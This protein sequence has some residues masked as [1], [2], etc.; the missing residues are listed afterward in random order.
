MIFLDQSQCQV[1]SRCDPGRRIH[2]PIADKYWVRVDVGARAPLD[3]KL[4]P[5]PMSCRMAA[6]QQA[7]S[8]QEHRAGADRADSPNSSSDLPEPSHYFSVYLIVLNGGSPGYEQGVDRPANLPKRLMRR[9]SQTA[10][11]K[12]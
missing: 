2:I 12:K 8:S 11:R 7:D 10:V 5:V 3:E 6:V 1:H 4:T 9:D